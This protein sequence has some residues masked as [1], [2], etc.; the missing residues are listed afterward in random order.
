MANFIST[1][2]FA[3]IAPRKARLVA[4]LIRG[5][6]VDDAFDLLKFSKKRAAVMIVKVL[7]A[8]VASADAQQV[9]V[10]DLYVAESFCDA[11]PIVKRM[12]PKDRGKSYRILKRT[13][14][15]TV[16]VAEGAEE[17]ANAAEDRKKN[18]RKPR[19]AKA[20]AA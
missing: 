19:V 8:A 14:H 6:S 13:C 17:R 18:K 1:W 20:K 15:I 12:M 3:K 9:N 2:R 4:D 16:G 10:S 11:G 5:K 7:K